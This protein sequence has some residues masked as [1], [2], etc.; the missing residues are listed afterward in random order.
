MPK[1]RLIVPLLNFGTTLFEIPKWHLDDNVFIARIDD[2]DFATLH[3][4]SEDYRSWLAATA[5]C[6]HLE[7]PPDENLDEHVRTKAIGATYVFNAFSA[8]NPAIVSHAAYLSK[9][10]EC[11]FKRSFDLQNA[12]IGNALACAPFTLRELD[13]AEPLVSLFKIVVAVTTARPTV[14]VTLDRYNTSLVRTNIYDQIID[15]TIALES[16]VESSTEIKFR[17]SLYGTLLA[18]ADPTRRRKTFDL[19]QTLYDARSAIVHGDISSRAAKKKIDA[20]NREFKEVQRLAL[21]VIS[22]YLIFHYKEPKNSW[23]E[24]LDN[25]ALASGVRVTT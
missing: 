19:L 18:E 13:T 2:Q 17:F 20:I 16:I 10:P 21:A 9:T 22:Y 24:H 12:P 5:I 6:I 14:L 3:R 1:N 8:S 25:L 23:K 7:D 15:I 4:E 11:H